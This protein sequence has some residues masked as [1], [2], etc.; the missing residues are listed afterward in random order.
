MK[1]GLTYFQYG[2][3]TYTNHPNSG[4]QFENFQIPFF[5]EVTQMAKDASSLLQE[6]LVG[7]DIGIS[8]NGPV[9]IEGNAY[10]GMISSQI[11]YGGYRKH[12]AFQKIFK[13][14]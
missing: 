9:L 12:P 11:S 6:R 8:D 14:I 13:I 7:W 3:K 4:I 5:S 2:A 1:K 10:Y